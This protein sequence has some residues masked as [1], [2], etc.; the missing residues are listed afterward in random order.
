MLYFCNTIGA[1]IGVLISG[2]LLVR[3]VGLP[4][5]IRIAGIINLALAFAV[6]FLSKEQNAETAFET[7]ATITCERFSVE[8]CHWPFLIASLLTGMASFI[9]EI[10]WIRMLSLV[11][12]S[13]T[14]SFELML[15]AFI[16]GLAFGGLWIKSR[17]IHIKNPVLYLITIQVVMG[18][19]ALLTLPLYGKTFEIMQ[20]LMNNV[21]KTDTGYLIFN[22]F[23]YSIAL[24][25]MLPTT[26]CAGMTCLS[27]LLLL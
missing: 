18:L 3:L 6:W 10:G 14:H 24:A 7:K 19:L 16:F 26:F 11:M 22:L 20:W 27:L 5:T 12:G 9:Y 1:A 23:G 21:P 15:S 17:F 8:G 13:S 2:F 25:V 4:G